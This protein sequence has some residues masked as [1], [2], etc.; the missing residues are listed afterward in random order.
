MCSSIL[1]SLHKNTWT[2]SS[3]LKC[4]FWIWCKCLSG[5]RLASS[6]ALRDMPKEKWKQC[7]S[8]HWQ[9]T[10]VTLGNVYSCGHSKTTYFGSGFQGVR[11]A[12]ELIAL[13]VKGM[14]EY[15]WV[16]LL[17]GLSKKGGI[18]SRRT[19]KFGQTHIFIQKRR[20][21]RQSTPFD[22]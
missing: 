21:K 7:G 10:G 22:E 14:S 3:S 8:R 4:M 11:F 18:V 13:D 19:Q 12:L 5:T 16:N 6:A 9:K 2:R 20:K 15:F 17:S 1:W